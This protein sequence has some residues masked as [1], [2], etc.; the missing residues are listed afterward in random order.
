M[1]IKGR[2]HG[3]IMEEAEKNLT[4]IQHNVLRPAITTETTTSVF[5]RISV[6]STIGIIGNSEKQEDI[7]T[8]NLQITIKDE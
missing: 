5:G 8:N 4:S 1:M 2:V 7:N 6:R 3:Q